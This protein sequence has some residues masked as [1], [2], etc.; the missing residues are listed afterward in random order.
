MNTTPQ[1]PSALQLP[2]MVVA[3]QS[4]TPK[5]H[6][7]NAAKAELTPV[8]GGNLEHN[9]VYIHGSMPKEFR[10][11]AEEQAFESELIFGPLPATIEEVPLDE[12]PECELVIT[13]CR[14]VIL[15]DLTPKKVLPVVREHPATKELKAKKKAEK[16]YCKVLP[17]F[18]DYP[19]SN[20]LSA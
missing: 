16:S 6:L 12:Y 14:M 4:L 5:M 3:V 17:L 13:N 10:M 20:Q 2:N 18:P 19:T 1:P 11:A 8:I 9:S 7:W 15:P